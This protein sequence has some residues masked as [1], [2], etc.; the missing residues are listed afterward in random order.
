MSGLPPQSQEAANMA[1]RPSDAFAEPPAFDP[2]DSDPL[3]LIP[4]MALKV[5]EVPVDGGTQPEVEPADPTDKALNL[6]RFSGAPNTMGI[7][8]WRRRFVALSAARRWSWNI[9]VA[10]LKAFL[11][12][13]AARLIDV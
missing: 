3:D 1:P 12:G 11:R 6:E 4:S 13:L 8:E 2:D 7:V 5:G 10:K 9:V